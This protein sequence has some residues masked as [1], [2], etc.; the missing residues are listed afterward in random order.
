MWLLHYATTLQVTPPQRYGSDGW[1]DRKV[2]FRPEADCRFLGLL[3]V[4]VVQ[5]LRGI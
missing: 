5:L 4:G 3:G 1:Y 2:P